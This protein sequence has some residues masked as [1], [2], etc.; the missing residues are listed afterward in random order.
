MEAAC[1]STAKILL[2]HPPYTPHAVTVMV[3]ALTFHTKDPDGVE[4]TINIFLFPDLSPSAGLEAAF[5]TQKW[6]AILGGRTLTSFTDTS[7]LVGK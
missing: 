7:L 1:Q 5:L 2:F 3:M 4:D 6:D